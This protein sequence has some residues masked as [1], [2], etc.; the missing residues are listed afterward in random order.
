MMSAKQRNTTQVFL[1]NIDF[2]IFFK[3][4]D[5][6]PCFLPLLLGSLDGVTQRVEEEVTERK[7]PTARET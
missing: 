4:D 1:Q 5:I 3:N 2:E 7:H 6:Q